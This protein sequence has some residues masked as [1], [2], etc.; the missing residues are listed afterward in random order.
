[1]RKL[2]VLSFVAL[3]AGAAG[4]TRGPC[5]ESWRP[6]Y[7]L[8]GAGRQTGYGYQN[9]GYTGGYGYQAAGECCDPC[10]GGGTSAAMMAAPSMMTADPVMTQAPC[11]Q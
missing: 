4:C 10:S 7:Y 6:G 3:A 11:C 8:F 2:L 1:M 5:G 9:Y